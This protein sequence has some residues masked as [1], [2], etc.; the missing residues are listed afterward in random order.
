MISYLPSI[1]LGASL[2]N[3]SFINLP[4]PP[5]RSEVSPRGPRPGKVHLRAGSPTADAHGDARHAKSTVSEWTIPSF[6]E[7]DMINGLILMAVIVWLSA[8]PS[9]RAT[10][11]STAKGTACTVRLRQLQFAKSRK[12]RSAYPLGMSLA[13]FNA[14]VVRKLEYTTV[15]IIIRNSCSSYIRVLKFPCLANRILSVIACLHTH[16]VLHTYSRQVN[17]VCGKLI[18]GA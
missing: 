8:T 12:N 6:E 7:E 14:L 10:G 9:L 13:S 3:A 11:D 18:H 15:I 17:P 5:E 2:N 1:F 4:V 16:I